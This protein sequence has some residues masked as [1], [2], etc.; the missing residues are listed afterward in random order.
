MTST[1]VFPRKGKAEQR[2]ARIEQHPCMPTGEAAFS[3][4]AGGVTAVVD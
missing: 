2:I 1:R 4:A 3:L